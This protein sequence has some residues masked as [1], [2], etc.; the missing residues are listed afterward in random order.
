MK[1]S[2]SVAESRRVLL[3]DD[4]PFMQNLL[5]KQLNRAGYKTES[6]RDGQA[7]IDALP[8][9]EAD[10]I[11]LDLMLPKVHG[12]RV[13]EAIRADQRHQST[14][15]VILSNAFLPEVIRKGI[16]LGANLSLHKSD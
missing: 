5:C 13:L 11:I 2:K 7:A 6:M 10:L 12:L 4:D 15:V 16:E 14:P 3:V 1:S 9:L 8:K